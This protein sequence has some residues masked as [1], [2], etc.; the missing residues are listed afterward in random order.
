MKRPLTRTRLRL[1]SVIPMKYVKDEGVTSEE[2]RTLLAN[3]PRGKEFRTNSGK[4][5]EGKTKK[6]SR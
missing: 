1:G 3:Q 5:G 2:M 6:P 4:L